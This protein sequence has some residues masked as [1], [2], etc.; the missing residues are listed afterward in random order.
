MRRRVIADVMPSF[1]DHLDVLRKFFRPEIH[2]K[3]SSLYVVSIE[4]IEDPLC[5]FI[6]PG[7]VK[8]DRNLF[9]IRIHAINRN[10]PFLAERYAADSDR[11]SQRRRHHK[12]KYL[13]QLSPSS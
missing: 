7:R 10:P 13:F 3:E 11:Y 5:E 8:T 1:R 9:F 4:N 6:A 12:H 2:Q